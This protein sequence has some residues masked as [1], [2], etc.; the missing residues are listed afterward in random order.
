M[1][2]D[3]TRRSWPLGPAFW[4]AVGGLAVAAG[5]LAFVPLFDLLGYEFSAAISLLASALVGPAAIGVVRRSPPSPAL[6][7]WLRATLAG[8]AALLL[9]LLI[10]LLNALRVTN[11]NP[12]QG[13][14]FYLLLPVVT[15]VVTSGWGTALALLIGRRWLAGLAYAGLWLAVA[16]AS[17]L[18]VWS[19]P[20]V[21]SY[22]QLVGW[23]AGPI[24]DDVIEP[25]WPLVLCRLQGLAAAA[26]LVLA[27]GLLRHPAERRLAPL[28]GLVISAALAGGLWL[29]SDALGFGRSEDAVRDRLAATTTSRHFVIHHRPGLSRARAG[30]LARDCEFRLHQIESLLGHHPL[31]P[32]QAWFFS[33]TDRK[34]ALVGAGRTQYAKPWQ[35][36]MFLNGTAFPHPTLKHE[37]VH[38]FA[39]AFGAPPFRISAAGPLSINPGLTEGLAVAVDWPAG[40]FDVHTWSAALRRIDRAPPIRGLFGPLGFWQAAAGRSYTLAGSFVRYLLDRYGPDALVAAYRH[41][42]LAGHYPADADALIADWQRFLDQRPLDPGTLEVARLRFSRRSVFQRTCAHE[43]AG[44]RRQAARRLAKGDLSAAA[45]AVAQL[46]E[47]LPADLRAR[48]V[49]IEIRLAQDRPEDAAAIAERLL[50]R[51]DLGRAAKARLAGRMGD[52]MRRLHRPQRAR[53]LQRQLLDAHLSDAADRLA[54]VKLQCLDR[55]APARPVLAFLESGRPDALTLLQ[56]H[57][58][59][60]AEADWGAAWYLLGRQLY[61]RGEFERAIGP[62]WRAA[63][64]GLGHPGL[65]TENLRLLAICLF[66]AGGPREP[67]PGRPPAP[68]RARAQAAALLAVAA[69]FPRHRGELLAALD[70]LQRL[71]FERNHPL[72]VEVEGLEAG[73]H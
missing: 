33:A 72:A 51:D 16:A 45:D 1:G 18:Q 52:V 20:E 41:G 69:E 3:G 46:L 67:D 64:Q 22:N 38:V 21:D 10:I 5:G 43:V 9:P 35:F 54:L 55:G 14:L 37:L 36:A 34:R 28:T 62:L 68:A 71:R 49:L 57:Q 24:Y 70:W 40:R 7:L 47:H 60:V 29:G 17:G 6:R 58:V 12:G 25:G 19:G 27:A 11:C 65:T 26:A 2:A 50:A 13:L 59:A 63:R 42:R 73:K 61:N 31:P 66:R 30:L 56:L 39:G 23:V 32:L 4:V 53:A 44:L 8:L 15:A 48:E